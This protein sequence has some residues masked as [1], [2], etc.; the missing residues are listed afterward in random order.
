VPDQ[1]ED[2]TAE[3]ERL[4]KAMDDRWSD[5]HAVKEAVLHILRR[6]GPPSLTEASDIER[7]E[8]PDRA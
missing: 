3:Y 6:L 4:L 5:P 7:R 1:F 8:A 2:L